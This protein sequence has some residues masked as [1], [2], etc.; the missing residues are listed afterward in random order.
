MMREVTKAEFYAFVGPKDVHPTPERDRT[1]WKTPS[2]EVLAI[3]TPGYIDS[4]L[5]E[6]MAPRTYSI[7]TDP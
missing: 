1:L 3:S 6:S 4:G 2:G 7:R 5:P